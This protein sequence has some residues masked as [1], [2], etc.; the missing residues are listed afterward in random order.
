MTHSHKWF[1]KIEGVSQGYVAEIDD[2]LNQVST[3]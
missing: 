1:C 3:A 2:T